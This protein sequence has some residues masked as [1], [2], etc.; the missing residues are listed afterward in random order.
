MTPARA[1]RTLEDEAVGV[2]RH[3][4]AGGHSELE[5]AVFARMASAAGDVEPRDRHWRIEATSCVGGGFSGRPVA[6][7]QL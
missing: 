7:R 2:G 5:F 6:C 4:V 1:F 3:P